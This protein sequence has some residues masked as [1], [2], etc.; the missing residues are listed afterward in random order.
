MHHRLMQAPE[1]VAKPLPSMPGTRRRRRAA[2]VLA[3][4]VAAVHAALLWPDAP[5]RLDPPPRP[6]PP[7]ASLSVRRVAAAEVPLPTAAPAVAAAAAAAADGPV[8]AAAKRPAPMGGDPARPARGAW[9]AAPGAGST[10]EAGRAPRVPPAA[11]APGAAPAVLGKA[12]AGA[13]AGAPGAT[14]ST[15]STGANAAA[16]PDMPIDTAIDAAIDSVADSAIDTAAAAA[17]AVSA[18][19]AGDAAAGPAAALP[20]YATRLPPPMR[21]RYALQR[22]AAAGEAQ[23]DWHR[24][25]QQY[26][27]LLQ[28]TLQGRALEGARSRGGIDAD[29]VAPERLA[30]LRAGREA[31]AAN[32]RRDVQRISYSGPTHQHP[33]WPGAQDRLSWM[34]QL[35]AVLEANPALRRPGAR[36]TL[37]VA[38]TGGD[39]EAWHFDV[40]GAEPLALPAGPVAAAL[41]LVREPARP[42]DQRIEVWLDP[43]RAHLPVQ[44][45]LQTVPGPQD[46]A[47]EWRLAAAEAGAR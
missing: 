37:F 3:A 14:G 44:V 5:P 39:A 33:L 32:F 40:A 20:V 35:P 36:I 15:G 25:G 17:A 38:G 29:G 9:P 24:D 23:L 27:L 43:A 10:P 13:A 1:H 11:A 45:R 26:V 30:A 46:A 8:H 22:G 34:I 28:R 31:R 21:L 12:S 2:A 4:A 16:M 47:T 19:V 18:D 41:R 42:Y 7:R 6:D